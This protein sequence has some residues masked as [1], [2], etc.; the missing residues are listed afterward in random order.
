MIE[1][2]LYLY[3]NDSE[4]LI[5]EDFFTKYRLEKIKETKN[6]KVINQNINSEHLLY[7]SLKDQHINLKEL[8]VNKTTNGKPYFINNSLKYNMSHSNSLYGVLYSNEEVGLD[9][10]YIDVKRKSISKKIYSKE[11]DFNKLSYEQVIK[12]FT[13]KESYIKYFDL[14]VF[15]DFKSININ[16]NQ[17]CGKQGCLYFKTFKYNNYYISLTSKSKFQLKSYIWINNK[18]EHLHI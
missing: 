4:E 1:L 9:I 13:I 8:E 10:E 7:E 6:N 5:S 16:K 11:I 14:T 3:L 18:I 2:K 12:D 17:V 15:H